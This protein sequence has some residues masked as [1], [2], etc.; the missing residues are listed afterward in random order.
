[1]KVINSVISKNNVI[2]LIKFIE[3]FSDKASCRLIFKE[4]RDTKVIIFRKFGNKD[5]DDN[6]GSNSKHHLD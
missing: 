6:E 2:Y 1:M 5:Q 4:Y 3:S